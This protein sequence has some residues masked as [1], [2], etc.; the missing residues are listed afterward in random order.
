MWVPWTVQISKSEFW[1]M[2]WWVNNM[3]RFCCF[4]TNK[5]SLTHIFWHPERALSDNNDE[6]E[7]VTNKYIHT[8]CTVHKKY[9]FYF[10]NEVLE[11]DFSPCSFVYLCT[12]W[13]HGT[14]FFFWQFINTLWFKHL[15]AEPLVVVQFLVTALLYDTQPFHL[16]TS[17][18]QATVPLCFPCQMHCI[19]RIHSWSHVR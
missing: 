6:I 18:A 5:G 12:Q 15:K 11:T 8:Y 10:F 2:W 4:T 13:V 1:A 17:E 7:T 16:I 19:A 14:Y 3:C 9:L